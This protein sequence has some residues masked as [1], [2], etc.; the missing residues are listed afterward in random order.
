MLITGRSAD[1]GSVMNDPAYTGK[2]GVTLTPE[3]FQAFFGD[4]VAVGP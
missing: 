4:G 2:P 1:G 3:Q